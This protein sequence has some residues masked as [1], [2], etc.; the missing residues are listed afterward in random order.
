VIGCAHCGSAAVE[1]AARFGGQLMTERLRC[2]SCGSFFEH[3]RWESRTPT[4]PGETLPGLLAA[5]AARDAS[6]VAMRV[7]RRGL[8]REITWAEYRECAEALCHGLRALGLQPGD[9]VAILGDPCPEWLFAEMAALCAG[10]IVFGI[11]PTSSVAQIA[12]LLARAEASIAVVRDQEGADKILAIDPP[13]PTLRHIVVIDP[14]G[15]HEATDARLLTL[16]EVRVAAPKAGA[17][18]DELLA[19]L[20][21]DDPALIVFTSGTSG[22]PRG[23]VHSHRTLIAGAHAYRVCL[24]PDLERTW[25]TV[26]HL[27]LNHIF[28]Q[29]NAVMLPLLAPVVPHFGE[30]RSGATETLFEIAPDLYASVPR[31]W[32]KLASHVLVGL[33]ASSPVKRKA[34]EWSLGISR[35]AAKRRHDC[36]AHLRLLHKVA[37]AVTFQPLLDKVGLR[38]V[39]VGVTAGG[40][41]PEEVQTLWQLWGVDLKNLYGQTEAG[42]V[43]AQRAGFPA[44]GSVGAP[45]DGVELRLGEDGEILVKSAGAFTG[46]WRDEAA[47]REVVAGGW[48]ATGDVGRW[49]PGGELQIVDRKRDILITEG[50]KN[51]APQLIEDRLRASPFVAEAVVF[52]DGRKYLS[53][54]IE[55]DEETVSQWARARN[56]AHGGYSD[57]A[58]SPEVAALVREL[59][60]GVNRELSRPEQ[61]KSFRLL[62]RS[63]DPEVE[64]EPVTPTR[65]VKRKQM[66]ERFREL[67]ESMYA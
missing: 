29:Y 62:P 39:R 66:Y 53:A 3:V 4:K 41:I 15:M 22:D 8:Y 47:T 40:P 34:Y 56:L 50:G 21:P 65:K 16:D 60:E 58:A 67:V 1:R 6:G 18:F 32:Q 61:I 10:G 46:Y 49:S 54:L 59:V 23:A 55:I 20:D 27:P 5:R 7:K 51:I 64:G 44:P 33:Q 25:R 45:A 24:V 52:G 37:R 11:Y 26:C 9:R 63:L 48:V 19:G 12:A 28:E 42:F 31:Y 43:A 57:L 2:S 30:R 17:R 38:R 14:Q 36:P 13:P 35:R